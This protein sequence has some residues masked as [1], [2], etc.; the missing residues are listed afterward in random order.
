VIK[1]TVIFLLCV[2]M[3]VFWTGAV[4]AQPNLQAMISHN[5][6]SGNGFPSITGVNIQINGGVK[7]NFNINTD[8]NGNFFA[9]GGPNWPNQTLSRG[10]QILAT[11][12][13]ESVSMV[14]QNLTA[15][16]NIDD[17]TITGMALQ[18][19]NQSL[20]NRKVIVDISD[21]WGSGSTALYH[22]ETLV[23]ASGT[24]IFNKLTDINYHL[25]RGHAIF[26]TLF[27]ATDG[28][29]TGNQTS[30][31]PYNGIPHLEVWFNNNQISGSG[32]P[33]NTGVTLSINGE[34]SKTTV[35]Q[36]DSAGNF[37][38][39]PWF[40]S[41]SLAFED[42]ITVDTQSVSVTV[43]RLP[44]LMESAT[45]DPVT[46]TIYGDAPALSGEELLIRINT[47]TGLYENTVS[48]GTDGNFSKIL[49]DYDFAP[50]EQIG[51]G[52]TDDSGDIVFFNAY[53]GIPTLAVCV[54]CNWI[55]GHGFPYNASLA[56]TINSTL[57][58]SITTGSN[59][60]FFI[61]AGEIN[62]YQI[63]L[64][65]AF[66]VSY[67]AGP[68]LTLS[69][70]N[71]F[72]A[73]ADTQGN[74]IS[75]T[76]SVYQ[77]QNLDIMIS[78]SNYSQVLYNSTVTLDG[79]GNFSTNLPLREGGNFDLVPGQIVQVIK[80]E[81]NGN[82]IYFNVYNAIPFLQAMIDHNWIQGFNFPAN[83]DVSIELQGSNIFNF[84]V[85]TDANGFFMANNSPNWSG[86]Q[87]KRGDAIKASY[88]G[89]QSSMVI[90]NLTAS[91]D[92]DTNI[93]SGKALTPGPGIAISG[94]GIAIN[95]SQQWGTPNIYN[96]N[97]STLSTGA[98]SLNTSGQGFDLLIS[99]KIFLALTDLQ[100]NQ[101][102]MAPYNGQHA[103]AVSL[104]DNT[105]AGLD[106]PVNAS[107][108]LSINS[109]SVLTSEIHTGGNG[110]FYYNINNLQY[111]MKAGDIVRIAYGT[112]IFGFAKELSYTI[113]SL[114]ANADTTG[115]LISGTATGYKSQLLLITIFSSS[116]QVLYQTTAQVAADG[117]FS[118]SLPSGS[119]N[120][121]LIPGQI[122]VLS[123]ASDPYAGIT[124]FN[125]T[126][127]F[128]GSVIQYHFADDTIK[129]CYE[130]YTWSDA[131][132]AVDN[133]TIQGP[134]GLLPY[135][136][137]DFTHD[138][139]DYRDYF[140]IVDGE[141]DIGTYTFTVTSGSNTITAQDTQNVNRVIPNPVIVSPADNA[142]INSKTPVFEWYPVS[143]PATN[144]Y[145]RLVIDEVSTGYRVVS[146]PRTLGML[147]YAVPE[148]V[149]KP[150]QTYRFQIRTPDS[151]DWIP[152]QNEGRSEWQTFTMGNS[153]N[154]A[155][156]PAIDL[157]GFGAL[158][159]TR[160]N[161]T[162]VELDA[163]VIDLDGVAANGTSHQVSVSTPYGLIKLNYNSSLSAF[164]AFYYAVIDAPSMGLSAKPGDY[165]FT[166]TD[167]DGNSGTL[168][169]TLIV[170]PLPLIN[171][172]SMTPTSGTSFSDTQPIFNWDA[173]SGAK[174]YQVRVYSD[175]LSK[176]IWSVNV[177][178]NSY[179]MPSGVL[180]P[181][182]AYRYRI[183]SRDAH[184]DLNESN[185]SNTPGNSSAYFRFTTGGQVQN[186]SIKEQYFG[187]YTENTDQG[188]TLRFK[189]K[190]Y[191][192]QG[193]PENIQSVIVTPPGSNPINL[194]YVQ[195]DP[196][197][198]PF[199]G[200]YQST[201]VIPCP[202][203]G[204]YTYVFHATDQNG[205]SAIELS[206]TITANPIGYPARSSLFPVEGT[207]LA[208]TSVY[209]DWT[210]VPGAA[211]YQIRIFDAD[212]NLFQT[213][214][215]S[216][217]SYHVP[218]GY[219]T[220]GQEFHYQIVTFR[221]FMDQL[222][223]NESVMPADSAPMMWFKTGDGNVIKG[224]VNNDGIVNLADVILLLRV[225]SGMQPS[226]VFWGADV[227]GDGRIGMP[228]IIY[229]LQKVAGLR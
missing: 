204:T 145:Y 88:N 160:D 216:E 195:G 69:V 168:T 6:I 177:G 218:P 103:F 187:S 100:G 11:Y 202:P 192:A 40:F 52:V 51:L 23:N 104:N 7:G 128:L 36:T 125:G 173:V 63:K 179:S 24:F 220:K 58:K 10:D 127:S 210:D 106:F 26:L 30:I 170:N 27:D 139:N 221:E 28:S 93:I 105:I 109:N 13:L 41:H 157:K 89:Q 205:N 169:D 17:N 71:N 68:S 185:Q 107:L 163:Y 159:L 82:K 21:K 116:N 136:K 57:L 84:N 22:G 81:S 176:T 66:K 124:V 32:F 20:N 207:Q 152:E 43:P 80:T 167:P 92:P 16:V 49:T 114:T 54:G 121:D 186:P 138:I 74:I 126:I 137:A 15:T 75:G 164:S 42:V 101:T 98:F 25:V 217:S 199:S 112:E 229:D 208:D 9:I 212:N 38:F 115:N 213:L 200:I 95:I 190:I 87:L 2:L 151:S 174:Y 181:N 50:G 155:A 5:W 226:G 184:L 203:S 111:I 198:T 175:D 153:L 86:Y 129:T 45:A 133:I 150:G 70:P 12:G 33:F 161:G 113:P 60:D 228:E 183:A 34:E 117:H 135:T 197:N 61:N 120:F 19:N 48:V 166:V 83:T 37:G 97:T 171:L 99:Q 53:N 31:E 193:V 142:T 122:I 146:T 206:E 182:T 215:T 77:G 154:H 1:K 147:S 29:S 140:L 144:I 219:L 222:I 119:E 156:V 132:A 35:L 209:F 196:A 149:L 62:N 8:T 64:G 130:I 143:Y 91:V 59:G 118:S 211:Y 73:T 110:N 178:K 225:Q 108:T 76:A 4:F 214:S 18:P 55:Q 14:V 188:A 72:S 78:N 172:N 44:V 158:A 162:S 189:V 47:N 56:L 39:S 224:D 227:N 96:G 201:D 180:Q 102:S 165:I 191:D 79:N 67:D 123:L 223:D 194:S 148:N 85:I 134:K 90:Q 3:M 131:S 94:A 65:D 141:P 46:N